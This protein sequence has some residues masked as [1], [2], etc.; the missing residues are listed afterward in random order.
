MQKADAALSSAKRNVAGAAS[1]L[2]RS[3]AKLPASA[4]SLGATLKAKAATLANAIKT[5][6]PAAKIAA[7]RKDLSGALTTF[8][9][10]AKGKA[11]KKVIQNVGVNVEEMVREAAEVQKQ[12]EEKARVNAEAAVMASDQAAE[13]TKP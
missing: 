1:D 3:I 11:S 5:G 10:K 9:N 6:T 7:L 2:G 12:Q 8:K 13:T 4:R